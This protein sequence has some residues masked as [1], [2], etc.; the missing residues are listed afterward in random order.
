MK[1]MEHDLA[2]L[3][4]K[5]VKF[6]LSQAKYLFAQLLKGVDYLHRERIIHRDIKCELTRWKYPSEQQRS[7]EAGRFWAGSSL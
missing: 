5:E 7:A 1:Y 3:L 6:N 2:T 4:M